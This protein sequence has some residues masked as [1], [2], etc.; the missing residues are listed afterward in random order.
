[1]IASA[2]FALKQDPDYRKARKDG[3]EAQVKVCVV[4]DEG[5]AV[6]NASVKVFMGMNFRPKGYWIKGETDANGCFL[7]QGRTCGDEIEIFVFKNGFY[8]SKIRLCFSEMGHEYDVRNGKW[9][10]YGM[11][12]KV[13]LRKIRN[14]AA[15]RKFGFGMGREVP[16]TNVWIGV[17]MLHGDFVKPYGIGERADFEVM[18]EWDGRTPNQ[19]GYCAASLRFLDDFSGGYYELN[20]Q[21]SEYPYACKAK[22]DADYSVSQLKVIDRNKAEENGE[23]PFRN[24][25]VLVTRTRCEIDE[26]G[27]L[28]SA[29]YGLIKVFSADASWDGKPTMRLSCVF[30]PTPND[31]NLEPK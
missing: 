24:N 5:A 4:D 22:M 16:C 21:E 13:E 8:N 19:S 28:K 15:L 10:P 29:C 1:M 2:A 30:N 11:I 12:K 25:A 26:K 3:A 23:R 20:I 9:L 27:E 14:P 31:T 17:D 6:S 7:L 18:V